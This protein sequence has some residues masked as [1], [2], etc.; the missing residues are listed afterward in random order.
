MSQLREL[1]CIGGPMDRMW[2]AAMGDRFR[3]ARPPLME[4][5]IG[6][7]VE[8]MPLEIKTETYRVESFVRERDLTI[9]DAWVHESLTNDEAAVLLGSRS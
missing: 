6:G 2:H 7:P 9:F 3:I 5:P 1:R 8:P 4:A